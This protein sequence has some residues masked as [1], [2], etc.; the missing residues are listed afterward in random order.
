MTRARALL[1]SKAAIL[2][3]ETREAGVRE[4]ERKRLAFPAGEPRRRAQHRCAVA[5]EDEV[6]GELANQPARGGSRARERFL[7][8]LT[9]ARRSA[10]AIGEVDRG[11]A[12][13]QLLEGEQLREAREPLAVEP[14][15]EPVVD[16]DAQVQALRDR[17]GR[18]D[19]AQERRAEE[20]G[21]RL[22]LEPAGDRARLTSADR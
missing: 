18:F 1:E 15:G 22:A 14:L 16:P 9:V 19:A 6:A 3:D 21:D 11:H 2:L 17:L 7:A 10:G 12:P 4:I 8:A 5:H 13:R 20:M